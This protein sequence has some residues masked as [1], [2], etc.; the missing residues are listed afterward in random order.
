MSKL[1]KVMTGIIT[2][3]FVGLAILT[4]YYWHPNIFH[5]FFSI[6]GPKKGYHF[7]WIGLTAMFAVIGFFVNQYWEQ[8]KLRA[9]LKYKSS[10]EWMAKYRELI[11]DFIVATGSAQQAQIDYLMV[12]NSTNNDTDKLEP[13]RVENNKAWDHLQKTYQLLFLYTPGSKDTPD[14]KYSKKVKLM[15]LINAVYKKINDHSKKLDDAD[16]GLDKSEDV[17]LEIHKT[18]SEELEKLNEKLMSAAKDYL[19]HEWQQ[20]SQGK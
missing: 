16:K 3:F 4:L 8:R 14:D 15:P 2:I 9:D 1:D 7:Q 13:F 10:I 19:G 11:A 18:T 12:K 20:A 6:D 5:Y 17:F